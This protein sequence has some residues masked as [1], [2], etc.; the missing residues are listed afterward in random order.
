[1]QRKKKKK[2]K[3]NDDIHIHIHI[4]I[5]R[6]SLLMVMIMMNQKDDDKEVKPVALI[7]NHIE[8]LAPAINQE[9]IDY[10]HAE[11]SEDVFKT[12]NEIYYLEK[13]S[14]PINYQNFH[15]EWQKNNNNDNNNN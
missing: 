4:H 1:M 13:Q 14:T 15:D 12:K 5:H 10:H 9:N 6:Y 8:K 2:L 11:S 7:Q 3:G